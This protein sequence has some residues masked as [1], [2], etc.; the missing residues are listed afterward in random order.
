[1]SWQSG[2]YMNGDHNGRPFSMSP[3]PCRPH[4]YSPEH[5]VE[6]VIEKSSSNVVYPTLTRTNCTEWSLVMMVNLQAA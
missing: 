6:R 5:I 4:H 1:M 2:Q 3:P